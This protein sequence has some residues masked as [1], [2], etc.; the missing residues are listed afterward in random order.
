LSFETAQTISLVTHYVIALSSA[1]LFVFGGRSLVSK[2]LRIYAAFAFWC[3]LIWFF[4]GCPLTHM[5]NH[6]AVR[7]YGKPFYPNYSYKDS[8]LFYI[9]QQWD[10]LLPLLV[11]TLYMIWQRRRRSA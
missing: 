1:G 4:K 9:L 2:I 6:I 5:E 10:L 8:D 7:F 3:G 11:V